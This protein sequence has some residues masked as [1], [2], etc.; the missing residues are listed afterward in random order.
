MVVK[1][2]HLIGLVLLGSPSRQQR[3]VGHLSWPCTRKRLLSSTIGGQL[4]ESNMRHGTVG[5]SVLNFV[6]FSWFIKTRM[7]VPY[8]IR[9]IR[10]TVRVGIGPATRHPNF[11][12]VSA[13]ALKTCI[14]AREFAEINHR[15]S[16]SHHTVRR[17]RPRDVC[18][19]GGTGTPFP[20]RSV[21]QVSS[22]FVPLTIPL[23][24]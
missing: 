22:I 17:P 16:Q 21:S 2:Q 23:S 24:I 20:P 15:L 8:M 11:N 7:T 4:L 9:L 19:A 13:S 5:T 10:S 18:A 1:G 12:S 6:S 14:Q 3:T